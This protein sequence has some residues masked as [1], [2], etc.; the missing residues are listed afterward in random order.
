[1]LEAEIE[2]F[3]KAGYRYLTGATGIPAVWS[4]RWHLKNG[5][6]ITGYKRSENNNYD[7]YTFLKPIALDVMH[8]PTDILWTRPLAP[9][10]AKLHYFASY[11]VTSLVKDR[12]GRLTRLGRMIKSLCK[13]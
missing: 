13:S 8:H 7:T 10:T 11:I 1:M 9:V 5:Y 6:Y 12:K 2:R 3:R 4:V